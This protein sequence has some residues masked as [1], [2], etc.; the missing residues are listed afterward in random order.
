VSGRTPFED[1][2]VPVQRSQEQVRV[3]LKKH[4]AL[5]V[6]FEEAWGEEPSYRVRFVWPLTPTQRSMIRLEVKPL[7]ARVNGG[8]SYSP[9]QRERQAWRGLSWY[10]DSTIKAAT[11][12]LIRF[13]DV[14]LSFIEMGDGTSRTIGEVV[15]PHLEAGLPALGPGS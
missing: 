5:G 12:G 3:L 8:K 10:L 7:P 15:I 4:G 2:S 9:E 14:F 1:T 13:E 11:F 6:Q